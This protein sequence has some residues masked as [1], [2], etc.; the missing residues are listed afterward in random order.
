[1]E[2]LLFASKMKNRGEDHL[3]EANKVIK[4][5]NLESCADLKITGCS[6]GQCRRVSI[7]V[8]LISGPDI[9]VLDE[10]TSGLDSTNAV[11]IIELLRNLA[12]RTPN[13]PIIVTTIHQPNQTIF[14]FF[15]QIYLLSRVGHKIY[16]GSP[17]GIL[18]HFNRIPGLKQSEFSSPADY[19][20][21]VASGNYGFQVFDIL[22]KITKAESTSNQSLTTLNKS[23]QIVPIQKVVSKM[24]SR[25][26]P[27]FYQWLLLMNRS[28]QASCFKSPQLAFKIAMNIIIAILISLLWAEPTGVEDG[29]WQSNSLKESIMSHSKES[30]RDAYM[31][32]ITK[33]TANCN[34]LFSTCIYFILVYSIGTVLV[35]P[36]EI[37]TVMKE[38]SNSWYQVKTYFLAKTTSDIPAIVISIFSLEAICWYATKQ[39]PVL[40]RFMS[41]L[42]LSCLM[43]IICESIG[44]LYGIILSYDLVSATLVTMASSFPILMFAGF[45]I[46]VADIPWY[47][48]SMTYISYARYSFEGILTSVYGFGRCQDYGISS[49]DFMK[50]LQAAQNPIEF[51]STLWSNFNITHYDAKLYAP[52]IGVPESHLESVI[53]GTQ[54]FLG[55]NNENSSSDLPDIVPAHDTEPSYVMSYFKLTDDHLANSFF[56][57]ITITIILKIAIFSLLSYKTKRRR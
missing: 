29:C 38:M 50:E 31:D 22:E 49:D 15:D 7:G 27:S 23:E 53:N 43:G 41:V 56:C 54:N 8:E 13:G 40:W 14:N 51:I 46:K 25:K 44:V 33:I 37:A 20:I 52:V 18:S 12:K 47:F 35:I 21:E 5:L 19:A 11:I 42:S 9:L 16:S 57:L 34:L 3:F 2:T 24:R 6:G 17:A 10:P 26:M 39:V 32:K 36:L 55:F 1:M 4:A 48:S 30:A 45:L 28:I